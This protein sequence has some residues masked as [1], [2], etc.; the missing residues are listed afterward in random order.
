MKPDISHRLERS[1]NRI[2]IIHNW[3]C[4][5]ITDLGVCKLSP[6]PCKKSGCPCPEEWSNTTST[7]ES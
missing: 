7:E 5:Y 2:K 1:S 6:Y 3:K 4:P